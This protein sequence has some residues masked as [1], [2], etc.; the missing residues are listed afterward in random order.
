MCSVQQG[1]RDR[2]SFSRGPVCCRLVVG[3][4]GV[5][6][7]ADS[8][9]ALASIAGPLSKVLLLG[10]TLVS[11]FPLLVRLSKVVLVNH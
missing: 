2:Q 11:T 7:V 8:G 3:T 4:V 5:T 6:S 9:V 1:G 10:L